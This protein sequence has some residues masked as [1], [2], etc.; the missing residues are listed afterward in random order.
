MAV[1]A[2][3]GYVE[4]PEQDAAGRDEIREHHKRI[5]MAGRNREIDIIK[6][7]G[8][9][10][11]APLLGLT[12]V[13]VDIVETGSTLQGKPFESDRRIPRISVRGS[14]RIKR[15]LNLK[16]P[17]S[18][19]MMHEIKG[20]DQMSRFL[21]SKYARL[22]SRTRRESSQ[23]VLEEADQAQYQRESIRTGAG[24]RTWRSTMAEVEQAAS[25][26]RNRRAA[27]LTD[28]AAGILRRGS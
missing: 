2:P 16:M 21:S 15:V 19:S 28:A 12:D 17:S 3:D 1:A 27:P 10:E 26:T 20:A 14:L 9:I 5:S 11:L 23:R 25:F 7:N 13:I 6:L 4:D 22:S 18:A 8:S 24:G